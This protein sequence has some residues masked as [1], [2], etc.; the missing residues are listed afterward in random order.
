M[1]HKVVETKKPKVNES[2]L[3][4]LI[5]NRLASWC[6]WRLTLLP[7]CACFYAYKRYMAREARFICLSDH[8]SRH[9][10]NVAELLRPILFYFMQIHDSVYERGLRLNSG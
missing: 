5:K 10:G 7:R 8:F 1:I 6:G 3:K 9:K 2:L 4:R